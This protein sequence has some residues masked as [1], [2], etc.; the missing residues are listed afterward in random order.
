M[1]RNRSRRKPVPPTRITRTGAVLDK[2]TEYDLEHWNTR[3]F[4]FQR[5]SDKVY[6]QLEEA[7]AQN[8]D[9]LC[10]ALQSIPSIEVRV[11]N[12]MRVTDYRWSLTP[13]SSAGSIKQIGGR[14]NIGEDID[15][16]RGK[17]FPALYI[18][19]TLETCM[20]EFFSSPLNTKDGALTLHELAL[21][22]PTSF[23]TFALQG[24]IEH[25]LDLRRHEHLRPF[26][27]I[28]RKFRLSS[29]TQRF[30]RQANLPPRTLVNTTYALWKRVLAPS[31]IWRIEPNVCGIPASSQIFGRFV[32]D[33]GFEAVLYPSQQGNEE[34][35]AI[36]PEN[37]VGSGSRIEIVGGV[38]DGASCTV[39]DKDHACLDGTS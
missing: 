7:R 32:R 39:I 22:R 37:F 29:E 3:S 35:M 33:V 16:A 12:W 10:S 27:D 26:V 20:C 23:T 36:F 25:V 24:H 4:D 18:G 28:I 13:L 5:Y 15:R 17:H 9:K 1:S 31:T 38:P 19:Q 34:C 8:Y 11:D 2:F 6:F 21:R 14:F 30:G